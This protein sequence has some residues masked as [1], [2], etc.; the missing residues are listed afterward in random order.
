M[1]GLNHSQ[2]DVQ[3]FELQFHSLGIFHNLECLNC[4]KMW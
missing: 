3:F 2:L 4:W 1:D